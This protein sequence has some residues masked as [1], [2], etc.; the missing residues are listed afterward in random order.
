MNENK[1]NTLLLTVIGVA[2]LLVAVIGA[3]F[4]YFTAQLSGA[5]TDTTLTVEAGTLTISYEGGSSLN[6]AG[7]VTAMDI[8]PVTDGSPIV[9]KKFTIT[10]SNST[11]TKMPYAVQINF[12][13]NEF[14]EPALLYS[15]EYTSPITNGS[16]LTE[17]KISQSLVTPTDETELAAFQSTLATLLGTNAIP[18]GTTPFSLGNAYFEGPV[19][20]NVHSYTLKIYFPDDG[21]N[22]DVHK[23]KEFKAN[24]GVTVGEIEEITAP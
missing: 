11:T 14:T 2:T 6:P 8:I 22:Q 24:I 19:S 5:E 20:N 23:N 17:K 12:T 9:T 4:A 21:A 13:T 15:L 7:S 16:G 10:G 1:S 3:S 18:I